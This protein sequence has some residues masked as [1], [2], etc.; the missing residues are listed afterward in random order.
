MNAAAQHI[1]HALRTDAQGTCGQHHE[2]TLRSA[3]QP[4]VSLAHC[5]T[6]GYEALVRTTD[7]NGVAV[8]PPALFDTV[9][10]AAELVHLDRLCRAVHTH[11]FVRHARNDSWLFL[12]VHPIVSVNGR[13]YG[14]FFEELLATVGLPPERIVIEILEG[15]MLDDQQLTSAVSF[16]RERGC[17]VALDD[18]GIGHSNFGRIWQVKPHIVKLDRSTL[19]FARQ[20]ATARRVLP[21]LVKLLHEAG[22]I[23]LIEGIEDEYEAMLAMES[24]AELAQGYYFARPAPVPTELDATSPTIHTLFDHYRD[25]KPQLPQ[26]NHHAAHIRLLPAAAAA[27]A[28]STT[29]HCPAVDRL[30]Q[31]AQVE[32]CYLIDH[33][34][35]Q[36]G[37]SRIAAGQR[38]NDP[39]FRPLENA[40]DAIWMRRSYW[41]RAL[42]HF[43]E[44]Q[45]TRPYLSAS[46][47][48]LCVT[49]SISFGNREQPTVLCLD[50]SHD[51]SQ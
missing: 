27:V 35:R 11:N 51:D 8:A 17:L 10:D 39:R 46:S 29:L 1:L 47:G 21:R 42:H 33:E 9:A 25:R 31:L 37:A 48:A 38:A 15:D 44:V 50:L 13:L 7:S 23:V 19:I 30:L 22:C 45:A 34:G 28:A 36:I 20:D 2:F 49:L 14:S 40:S 41:R 3:F 24:D 6:V 32:R 18:F 43:G 16:Y 12:N 4:I 26:D 5:R